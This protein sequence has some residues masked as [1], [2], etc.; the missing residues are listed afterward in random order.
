MVRFTAFPMNVAKTNVF[1][2][3]D[4][5]EVIPDMSLLK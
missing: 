3:C 5:I 1:V 4:L 2:V